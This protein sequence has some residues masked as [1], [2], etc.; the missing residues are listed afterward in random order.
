MQT[1]KR[2]RNAACHRVRLERGCVE[3]VRPIRLRQIDAACAPA[4]LAGWIEWCGSVDGTVEVF[5]GSAQRLH[6]N[7]I[8]AACQVSDGVSAESGDLAYPIF[9]TQQMFDLR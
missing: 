8:Q 3:R 5:Y 1:A 6:V 9:V 4:I 2:K 7:T